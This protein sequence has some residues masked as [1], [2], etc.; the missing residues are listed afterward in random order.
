M[1]LF[2]WFVDLQRQRNRLQDEMAQHFVGNYEKARESFGKPAKAMC[3]LLLA[4]VWGGAAG[5]GRPYASEIL[6]SRPS[7]SW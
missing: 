3:A 6:T 4:K 7:E 5:A 2:R 1:Q